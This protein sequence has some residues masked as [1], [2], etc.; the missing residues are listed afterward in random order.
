MKRANYLI[1]LSAFAALLLAAALP[2]YGQGRGQG[3]VARAY[4]PATETTIGGVV[5]EVKFIPGPGV[6]GGMHLVLSTDA[7]TTEVRLGP[8]WYVS[9]QNFA[10]GKG[11]QVE[12][13]GS[14]I[15][16]GDAFV[17]IAR[18]VKKGDQVLT[19]RN[20]QGIPASSGWRRQ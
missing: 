11:D 3:R 12:V 10:F 7:G 9:R 8:A 15:K 18:V 13:T 5:Q 1:A 20:A 14:K 17:L 16:S 4:D 2:A 19:L 6:M